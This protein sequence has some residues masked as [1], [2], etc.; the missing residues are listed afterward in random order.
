[1]HSGYNYSLLAKCECSE[2]WTGYDCKT[3]ICKAHVNPL[4]RAQLMTNDERKIRIFEENPC[5]MNGF[6]SL[7]DEGKRNPYWAR[8]A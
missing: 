6:S 7:Y 5:G 3:P 8:V 2:G 4:I 1:M